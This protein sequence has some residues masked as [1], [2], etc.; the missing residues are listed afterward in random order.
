[1]LH[2]SA[3]HRARAL[4]R[5]GLMDA[6][7]SVVPEVV[8]TLAARMLLTM[9]EITTDPAVWRASVLHLQPAAAGCLRCVRTAGWPAHRQ[10]LHIGPHATAVAL[11]A[12][13]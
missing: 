10:A 9:E 1:M 8:S 7:D 5:P 6:A 12:S 13:A 11:P 2:I 3:V 4:R